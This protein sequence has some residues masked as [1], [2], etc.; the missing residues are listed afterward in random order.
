MNADEPNFNV[1]LQDLK[2][3]A[4]A[5]GSPAAASKAKDRAVQSMTKLAEDP[6]A[7]WTKIE[8]A[9][10]KNFGPA[11]YSV[12]KRSLDDSGSTPKTWDNLRRAAMLGSREAEYFLGVRYQKG[13]G[14]ELSMDRSK[15]YFRLCA[16]GGVAECQE[17]LAHLMFDTPGRPDYEYE[18]ALAWFSLAAHQGIASARQ[19]VERETPNLPRRARKPSLR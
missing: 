16:A 18:Q 14:V 3:A 2:L 19:V 13:E 10:K 15:N 4:L 9:A 11:I 6:V 17:R 1:A 5:S 7:G 8:Q 12:A